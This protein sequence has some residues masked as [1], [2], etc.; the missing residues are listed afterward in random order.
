MFPTPKLAEFE[1][2]T[3]DPQCKPHLVAI[4]RRIFG[5]SPLASNVAPLPRGRL[6]TRFML[7]G[8]ATHLALDTL[9]VRTYEGYPYLAFSLWKPPRVELPPK[10]DRSALAVRIAI[11]RR[12]ARILDIAISV[13][14]S[15]DEADAASLA[16][17]T[18][19]CARSSGMALAISD[20]GEGQFLLAAP[21]V[22]GA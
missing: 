8:F 18:A 13:P 14:T 4:A 21:P 11:L 10:S 2:F 15:L 17:T 7:A 19:L 1:A 22:R 5:K 12:L 6:F 9:G 16:I 3:A 20:A